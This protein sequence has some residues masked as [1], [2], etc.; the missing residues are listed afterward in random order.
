MIDD[1]LEHHVTVDELAKTVG[2]PKRAFSN[3]FRE[4]MALPVYQYV[5][6]RRADLAAELLT[7]TEL[8]LA[9]VA[10]RSGFSHQAHMTRF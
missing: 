7:T 9:E 8:P 5:L 3:A 2:M 6:G 10:Q 1:R 4:A